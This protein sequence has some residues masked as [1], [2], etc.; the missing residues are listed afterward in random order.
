MSSY[1]PEIPLLGMYQDR[2]II[3]KDR[4]TLCVHNSQDLE[5]KTWKQPKHPLTDEW[6]DMV[7]VFSGTLLSHKNEIMPSAAS[8]MDLQNI[9]LSEI[10]QNEERQIPYEITY[11]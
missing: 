2:T 10:S 5:V 4:C 8:W 7:L 9:I 6:I 3:Q 1:D 11:L